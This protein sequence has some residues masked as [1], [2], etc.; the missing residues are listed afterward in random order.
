MAEVLSQSQIDA[1]LAAAMSG[2]QDLTTQKEEKKYLKYDFRSP[3]KY[4]KER[5]KMLNGVFENYAKVLNTRINGLARATCEVEVDTVDEQRY[6]EFSNALIDGQVVTLAYLD[7][8]G[9]REE[10][11]VIIVATPS[12]IVSLI[13]RLM[14][15]NGDV[16]EDLPSDYTYTDLDLSLYQNLMTDFVSIMGGSWENYISLRFE[17]GRIEANPTLVQ[18]IGFEETVIMVSLDIKFSNSSGRLDI[19]LPDA[20]LSKIFTEINK[21]SAV[22]RKEREDHSDD[23]YTH[24]RT[25]ELEITAELGRTR[26]QL[27]D[28]YNLSVGDVIDMNKKKDSTVSLRIGGREWFAGYMGMHDK[29]LAVKI[30]DVQGEL[31]T[32]FVNAVSQESAPASVPESVPEPE[33][34]PQ[35]ELEEGGS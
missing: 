7:I 30:R 16:E 31:R 24:L 34:I 23:I 12:I 19:C 4:T 32:E 9:D 17:Y 10:T 27:K 13:D 25:S 35:L 21:G 33:I 6:Y 11:P 22:L 18:L 20:V 1:L 28:I 29:H 8:H 14:G 5:L 3:R 2:T 15:G 26:L